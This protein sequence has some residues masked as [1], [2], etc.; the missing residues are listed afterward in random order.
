MHQQGNSPVRFF[1]FR[2]EFTD[3]FDLRRALGRSFRRSLI[4]VLD[5]NDDGLRRACA[6]VRS[7]PRT[8]GLVVVEQERRDARSIRHLRRIRELLE[9][10][11]LPLVVLAHE[12]DD[13]HAALRAYEDGADAFV[14]LPSDGADLSRACSA[15]FDLWERLQLAKSA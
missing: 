5:A 11:S 1:L 3:A 9:L 15:V 6:V 10:R 14:A 2:R 7:T 8:S 4:N 12:G 13:P